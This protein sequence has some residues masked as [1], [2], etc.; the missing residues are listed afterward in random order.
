MSLDSSA[1]E[2]FDAEEGHCNATAESTGKEVEYE[3]DDILGHE[4]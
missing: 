2:D 1:E 4:R 3:V